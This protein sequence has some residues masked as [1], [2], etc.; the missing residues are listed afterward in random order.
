MARRI[1]LFLIAAGL[2]FTWMLLLPEPV[3]TLML[4]RNILPPDKKRSYGAGKDN[5]GDQH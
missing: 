1:S 4:T 3:P 2:L 5:P